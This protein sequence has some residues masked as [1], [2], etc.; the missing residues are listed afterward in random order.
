MSFFWCTFL[1]WKST[2]KIFIYFI[3][4][5]DDVYRVDKGGKGLGLGESG[6]PLF[7]NVLFL[8]VS[9]RKEEI[10]GKAIP[11]SPSASVPEDRE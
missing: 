2:H 5:V 9:R 8:F 6:R 3:L 10:R 4:L 7:P 1:F 11:S